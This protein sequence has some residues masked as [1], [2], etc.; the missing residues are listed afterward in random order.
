[1]AIDTYAKSLI[2]DVRKQ[3]KQRER[4]ALKSS[5]GLLAGKLI[6]KGV[7]SFVETNL[8]KK[9]NAYGSD[10]FSGAMFQTRSS[11]EV[12]TT[13][14]SVFSRSQNNIPNPFPFFS[15]S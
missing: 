14:C 1:M 10:T 5:F 7:K 9:K 15:A 12:L 2:S 4:D 8:E 11:Q 6:G 3:N 13:M